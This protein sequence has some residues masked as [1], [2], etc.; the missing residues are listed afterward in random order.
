M[1]S[2]ISFDNTEIAF[3][4][5]ENSELKQAHFLFKM[6][7]YRV[8]VSFQYVSDLLQAF[9]IIFQGL[10]PFTRSLTIPEVIFQADFKFSLSDI[11]LR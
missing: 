11:S 2:E 10:V 8:Q 4:H 5:R 3:A 1:N 6:L 9:V 7:Y